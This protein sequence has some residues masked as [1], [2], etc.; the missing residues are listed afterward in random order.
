MTDFAWFLL[1]FYGCAGAF[2]IYVNY[3]NDNPDDPKYKQK[4]ETTK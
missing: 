2:A 1:I 3:F 4:N